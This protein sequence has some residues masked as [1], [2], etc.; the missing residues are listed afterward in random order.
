MEVNIEHMPVSLEH[1]GLNDA[2]VSIKYVSDYN[3]RYISQNILAA[4]NCNDDNPFVEIPTKDKN[5]ANES[6]SY[7]DSNDKILMA[8][9]IYRILVSENSVTFNFSQ[10]YPGWK[11]YSNLIKR[12]LS[13][14]S[15]V[16]LQG[17]YLKYMSC[18][19][20]TDIFKALD[21]TIKL[22]QLPNF[23][24]SVF[25]FSC[26]CN[27]EREPIAE[28]TIKLT[29]NKQIKDST[30]SIVEVSIAGKTGDYQLEECLQLLSECHKFEK[31]LF[32]LLLSEEFINTLNPH[33]E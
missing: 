11:K 31:N 1:D 25:N 8:N 10:S 21:G 6:L 3:V 33:Y 5:V 18:F 30:V 20:N 12:V 13:S 24:G 14:I 19:K 23:N 28:A 7:K 15:Q 17:V 29:N 16:K 4:I 2:V 27:R 32:F 26:N 9:P 22:N